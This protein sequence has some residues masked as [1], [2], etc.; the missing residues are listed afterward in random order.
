[1]CVTI[2]YT[3]IVYMMAAIETPAAPP[4][5]YPNVIEYQYSQNYFAEVFL[6]FLNYFLPISWR[7]L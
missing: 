2:C 6:A 7:F 1:M 3:G 4:A 5:I